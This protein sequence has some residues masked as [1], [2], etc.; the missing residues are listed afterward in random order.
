MKAYTDYP[1]TELGDAPG[2]PAPIRQVHVRSY[3]GRKYCD[4]DVDG[5]RKMVKLG[6][7]YTEPGGE[8]IDWRELTLAK[9]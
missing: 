4:I 2:K 7:L 1:I 3:D 8:V 9:E 6:Y 5:V